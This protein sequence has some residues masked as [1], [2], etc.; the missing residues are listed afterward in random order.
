MV[1]YYV[2]MIVHNVMMIFYYVKMVLHP[3]C[4]YGISL[5]YDN[6]LSIY[7]T[8]ADLEVGGERGG[9]GL[10]N[11]LGTNLCWY[12]YMLPLLT[13]IHKK[14]T[15]NSFPFSFLFFDFISLG[16]GG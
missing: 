5:S 9:K 1:L 6:A 8:G 4:Y 12:M 11:F 14:E 13:H 16:V 3:P 7:G 10:Q 15:H 2:L